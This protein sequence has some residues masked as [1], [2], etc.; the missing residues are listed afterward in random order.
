[1]A[2][3]QFRSVSQ[4]VRQSRRSVQEMLAHL[5]TLRP[6]RPDRPEWSDC[7][8]WPDRAGGPDKPEWP[9]WPH[10]SLADWSII[11]TRYNTR[12]LVRDRTVKHA[13]L[14]IPVSMS[15]WVSLWRSSVQEMLAHL[16]KCSHSDISHADIKIVKPV[17][18][19]YGQSKENT[20]VAPVG[21]GSINYCCLHTSRHT[22]QCIQPYL[23][24]L[25]RPYLHSTDQT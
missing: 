1:M 22:V 6:G 8:G 13:K 24:T 18:L 14:S 19:Q 17:T 25:Y 10:S 20:C 15:E 11:P 2:N 23:K 12:G 3:L 16:K 21:R 5:K 9:G 4:S 7:S